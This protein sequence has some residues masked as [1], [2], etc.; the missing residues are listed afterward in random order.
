MD[1]VDSVFCK[2]VVVN[3]LFFTTDVDTLTCDSHWSSESP[4]GPD[5]L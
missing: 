2:Y 3:K 4:L 5:P 1:Q